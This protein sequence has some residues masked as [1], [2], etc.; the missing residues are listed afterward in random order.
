M[1]IGLFL[2]ILIFILLIIIIILFIKYSSLKGEIED[3]AR[4]LFSKW[5]EDE[6]RRQAEERARILFN[7]WR[8]SEEKR[9]RE[10]AIKRSAATIIGKVGEHLAPILIFAK[11]GINPKDIRFIGTPIDFIA[12]KGLSD[13]KLEEIVFI[14]VKSGKKSDL[15]PKEKM[16]RDV[17]ETRRIR[18]ALIHIPSEL[19]KA[20]TKE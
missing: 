13:E 5:A 6:L 19:D 10:D 14:E 8:Q 3:R 15:T 20:L 11:Y 12:F 1:V 2:Y 17:I 7:E 4:Q 18:W 9:I 16:V